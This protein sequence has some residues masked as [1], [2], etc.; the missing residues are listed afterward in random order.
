G[1]SI[2]N[3]HALGGLE[4][5]KQVREA[6]EMV[7]AREGL[8]R[9]LILAVTI[10][11]SQDQNALGDLSINEPLDRLVV[12]LAKLAA[13]AGLDGVVASA[14]EIGLVRAAIRPP[15]VILTPGLRPEWA[16][17]AQDQKRVLSP[18]EALNAGADYL[19]VGRPILDH[20]SPVE[21]TQRILASLDYVRNI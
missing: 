2:C 4:M 1:V 7:S 14:R 21:A 15:F 17:E 19:V 20:P 16:A 6:V 18:E 13:A 11:T 10:L 9:P 8:V 5:M 3:L 12:R